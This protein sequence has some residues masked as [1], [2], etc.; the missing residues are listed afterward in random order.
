MTGTTSRKTWLAVLALLALGIAA[1]AAASAQTALTDAQFHALAPSPKTAGDHRQLAA[2]YR[3]HAAE[4]D[5]DA[6]LHDQIY[7]AAKRTPEDD[8][9]WEIGQAARHYAEH[10]PE[11]AEP[12]RDLAAIHDGIAERLSKK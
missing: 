5:T 9:A 11:A 3:A 6:K 4:H 2:F 1:A 8:Q 10:S 12:L 7:A